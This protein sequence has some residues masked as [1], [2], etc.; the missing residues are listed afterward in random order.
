M[1]CFN[2]LLQNEGSVSLEDKCRWGESFILVYDVT[3]KYSFDELTRLK[4]IASYTHSRLRVNFTPCWVLIGNKADLSE[5]ERMVTIEE[6]MELAKDLG[7]HFFREISVKE[8]L[9]ESY[10]V[11][12]DLWRYF[13]QLSPRSP[14]SSQRRKF[15]YRIQDKIS[16]I[17]SA[18]CSCA[19]DALKQANN[20]RN[21]ENSVNE[22]LVT[23]LTS[24]LKRQLNSHINQK[25]DYKN[26]KQYL[27][28][29]ERQDATRGIPRIPENIKED[30]EEDQN[31]KKIPSRIYRRSRRNALANGGVKVKS[32]SSD[33]DVSDQ[34]S[35]TFVTSSSA[36]SSSA[37]L[38]SLA[39]SSTTLT[40]LSTKSEEI[41][42]VRRESER[43]SKNEANST[44]ASVCLHEHQ[45]Q[46]FK[47]KCEE[48]SF[49]HNNFN[50]TSFNK[51]CPV[52]GR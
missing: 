47:D 32:S 48:Q 3:D 38:S 51:T 19:A 36:S 16:V 18:T 8:S 17:D 27:S 44:D 34:S 6:G 14:S 29:E 7:C 22:V 15:L 45:S 12:E 20:N 25:F 31:A 28:Q 41:P 37:S 13:L 26:A 9:T 50:A 49:N 10:Q 4:F 46:K 40:S 39:S 33:D 35:V 11:F 24:T 43:F 23:T 1:F 21:Q 2:V 42:G 30:E 52:G 5:R